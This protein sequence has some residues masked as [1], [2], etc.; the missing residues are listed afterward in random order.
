V[1]SEGGELSYD[2]RD[3]LSKL[4]QR[5]Q[6]RLTWEGLDFVKEYV[7]GNLTVIVELYP[8]KGISEVASAQIDGKDG[9][10]GTGVTEYSLPVQVLVTDRSTR[11]SSDSF[12]V[13]SAL[14]TLSHPGHSCLSDNG[15]EQSMF[16]Q[17][18]EFVEP[19]SGSPRPPG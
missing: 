6:N 12:K 14:T 19:E 16:V 3:K 5:W 8:V 13:G 11:L 10:V 17:D 2:S 9:V 18:V 4:F 15:N 7:G 1:H